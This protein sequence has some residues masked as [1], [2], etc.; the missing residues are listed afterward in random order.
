[1]KINEKLYACAYN[2][3]FP[4]EMRGFLVPHQVSFDNWT[5]VH[6]R[7]QQYHCCVSRTVCSAFET[8]GDVPL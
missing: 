7:E 3:L 2:L 8:E 1:M 4:G 6:C 5:G